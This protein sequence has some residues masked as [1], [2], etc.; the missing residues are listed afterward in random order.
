MTP[1]PANS[2]DPRTGLSPMQIA[3]AL[4]TAAGTW[5]FIQLVI[6]SLT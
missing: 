6:R 3:F 5:F 2:N 1:P 4:G